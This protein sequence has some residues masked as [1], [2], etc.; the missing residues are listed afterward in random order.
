MKRTAKSV[1]APEAARKRR[2]KRV[3]VSEEVVESQEGSAQPLEPVS[4][5]TL[6]LAYQ[7]AHDL[8]TD[9]VL[10]PLTKAQTAVKRN[11]PLILWKDFRSKPSFSFFQSLAEVTEDTNLIE[12]FMSVFPSFL[13]DLSRLLPL[14]EQRMTFMTHLFWMFHSLFLDKELQVY[15]RSDVGVGIKTGLE[16]AKG[17]VLRA[18]WADRVQVGLSQAQSLRESGSLVVTLC[19]VETLAENYFVLF[20]PAALLPRACKHCCNVAAKKS[21]RRLFFFVVMT[22]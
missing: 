14:D 20:G 8:I 15:W 3:T 1:A 13:T 11:L 19:D 10:V 9:S 4:T 12:V 5:P 17:S 2:C 7:L 21:K 18:C 6:L 16:I 22:C